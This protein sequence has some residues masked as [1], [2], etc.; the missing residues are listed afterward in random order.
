ML[1]YTP[2][3]D[4]NKDAQTGISTVNGAG[5]MTYYAA[6]SGGQNSADWDDYLCGS[7]CALGTATFAQD[8]TNDPTGAFGVFDL[9]FSLSG[10]NQVISYCVAISVDKATK[11]ATKG[12]FACMDGGNTT[13]SPEILI[14]Q[15]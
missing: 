15:E 8:T 7:Q 11:S 13:Q 4:Y 6:D 3:G 2:S 12:R 14:V 1:G 5:V 9:N 10:T